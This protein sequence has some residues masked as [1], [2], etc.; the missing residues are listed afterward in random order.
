MVR[1]TAFGAVAFVIGVKG[2]K[3]FFGEARIGVRESVPQPFAALIHAFA[4]E[5]VEQ[6]KKLRPLAQTAGE[7]AQRL[8]LGEDFFFRQAAR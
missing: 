4:Q 5:A 7:V 8:I 6:L 2:N 3:P 1:A